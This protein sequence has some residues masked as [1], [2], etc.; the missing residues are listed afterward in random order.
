VSLEAL[1]LMDAPLLF[2]L[3]A[4]GEYGKL[5]IGGNTHRLGGTLVAAQD[6]RLAYVFRQRSPGVTP[7][8]E[9]LDAFRGI[10]RATGRARA[11]NGETA[12]REVM[13]DSNL[14]TVA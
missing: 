14:L 4:N 10:A 7:F 11:G 3:K 12:E 13:L 5:V 9:V 8:E 2:K 1:K 6:G